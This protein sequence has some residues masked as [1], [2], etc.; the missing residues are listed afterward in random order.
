MPKDQI[1]SPEHGHERHVLKFLINRIQFEWSQ[2]YIAGAE[3]RRLGNI[4]EE[5]QIFLAIKRPWEDELIEN[6]TKIDLARPEIEHFFSKER[7]LS[8]VLVVNGK[9]REW[10]KKTITFSE[11][12]VLAF[13]R[14]DENPNIVYTVTYDR[15]PRENPEGSMV[16]GDRV[17]T[18]ERMIF[19]VTTTDKS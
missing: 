10:H 8:I 15:G 6:D 7:Q 1:S 9:P 13:G 12:V 3:I 14:Y 2:Q 18:K 5:D 16:K 11:V 19:N 17:F 4:P